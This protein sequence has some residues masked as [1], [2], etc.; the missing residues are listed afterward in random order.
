MA[1]MQK[2][3][4]DEA[5][6]AFREAI[7]SSESPALATAGLGQAAALRGRTREARTILDE[8]YAAGREHYISP[9]AYVMLHAS[10]GDVDAS[11]EWLER[12]YADRRGWLAYLRVEPMLDPLRSDPRFLRLLERMRLV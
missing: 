2:S 12:A 5:A 9:V 11:F 10:L 3:M 1:Y 7:A 4:Y 8:L 6:A